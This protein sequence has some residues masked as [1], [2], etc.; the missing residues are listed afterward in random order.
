MG[1][2]A[3]VIAVA[4]LRKGHPN[5]LQGTKQNKNNHCSVTYSNTDGMNY[6][7]TNDRNAT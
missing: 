4:L 7:D 1:S 2:A 5:F 6:I 3:L